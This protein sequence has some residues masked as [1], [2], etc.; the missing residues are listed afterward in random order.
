MLGVAAVN[1]FRR[2]AA[3]QLTAYAVLL[4]GLLAGA[5]L[6]PAVAGLVASPLS[7]AVVAIV[8]LFSLAG[9]GDAIGWVIGSKFWA[10][11]RQSVFGVA[12]SVAGTFVALV[13]VFLATWFGWFNIVNGSVGCS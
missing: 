1:G 12:D 9:I 10:L 13:A 2:G 7:Q 8:V 4:M 5:L 11:A 6:A 3:L